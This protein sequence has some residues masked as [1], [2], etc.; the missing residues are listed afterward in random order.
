[1]TR[2]FTILGRLEGLSFLTLLFIA[3]PLKYIMH[4]PIVV[5][6]MGPLHGGLFLLYCALAFWTA[7]EQE[8]PLKQH[9]MA[10]VAAVIPFGPF[11]FEKYYGRLHTQ[12]LRQ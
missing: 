12:V 3:M 10:Y 2:G 9:L 7:S 8:W 4:E 11:L 5:K 1:M 6:I